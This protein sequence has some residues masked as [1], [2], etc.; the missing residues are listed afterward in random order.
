MAIK[1]L[2]KVET[3]YSSP[4]QTV[5]VIGAGGTGGHLVPNLSRFIAVVNSERSTR[6]RLILADGDVV[7]EKNLRRQNFVKQDL[8]QNKA[9]VLAKRYSRAFGVEIV[10]VAK[11]IETCNQIYNL[12]TGQ[13]G[14]I[15]VGCVDNIA[16]RKVIADAMLNVY[17]ERFWIDCGNEEKS[18][19][20]I[21]G[22]Y[23]D[24]YSP[25]AI[26]Y[27]SFSTPNVFEMYPSMLDEDTSFNSELSCAERAQSAPQ[28]MQTNVTAANIA[29]NYIQKI[30]LREP[31]MSHG[32]TF[33]IDNVFS[34]ELNIRENL[35][36]VD[37]QR[38]K[39]WEIINE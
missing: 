4:I 16:S 7:E 29:M 3:L 13:H 15:I 14:F 39:R 34:T 35:S 31:I 20:V 18:G 1:K 27:D 10:A 38:V 6:V 25:Y 11:D 22:H 17:R 33:S 5:L 30:I 12:T 28:N 32:V 36:K 2:P 8:N 24:S 26:S 37:K 9:E 23:T 19:Q 21:M